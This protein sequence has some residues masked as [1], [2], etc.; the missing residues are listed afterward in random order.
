MSE[1]QTKAQSGFK[2]SPQDELNDLRMSD[3]ALPLFNAVKAFIKDVAEPDGTRL[4]DHTTLVYGS[5][6]RSIHYLDNCP[7]L[8]AGGGSRIR[9]GEHVVV[10]DKTPLANLWL[11]LLKGAGVKAESHG[12]STGVVKELFS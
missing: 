10:P 4:F 9:L 2:L 1:T 6:I 8:V 3:K 11:T 5:N 12:D 7:T